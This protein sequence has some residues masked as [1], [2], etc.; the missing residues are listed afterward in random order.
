MRKLLKM[1]KNWNLK[2]NVMLT[3]WQR[4]YLFEFLTEHIKE[5][6]EQNGRK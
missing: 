5:V 2:N 1:L 6:K 4:I 3:K